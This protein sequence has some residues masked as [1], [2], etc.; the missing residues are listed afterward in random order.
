ML[1]A[2]YNGAAPCSVS[3][4]I[5]GL[6]L[7]GNFLSHLSSVNIRANLSQRVF[8]AATEITAEETPNSTHSFLNICWVCGWCASIG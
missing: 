7:G 8:A 2:L 6:K 3:M 5:C 4:F 1:P